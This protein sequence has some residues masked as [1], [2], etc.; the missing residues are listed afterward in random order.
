MLRLRRK[1]L[2]LHFL[3]SIILFINGCSTGLHQAAEK[4]NV[5]QLKK[6]IAQGVDINEINITGDTALHIAAKNGSLTSV[7]FLVKSGANIH[8]KNS[9]LETPLFAAAANGKTTIVQY[10]HQAGARLNVLN[11]HGNSP[12]F[13]AV[14]NGHIKTSTYLLLHGANP[15]LLNKYRETPVRTARQKGYQE[16]FKLLTEAK[17]KTKRTQPVLQVAPASTEDHIR[18]TISILHPLSRGINLVQT[19]SQI[20]IRGIVLDDHEVAQ[21]TINGTVV[22]FSAEGN[23][24]YSVALQNGQNQIYLLAIDRAGNQTSKVLTIQR[25]TKAV[26]HLANQ[27]HALIIGNN[28]YRYLNQLKTPVNDAAILADLLARNYGFKVSLIQNA[29]KE[30]ILRALNT[31]RRSLTEQDNLLIYY[32]GHGIYDKTVNKAYWLPVDAEKNDDTRWIIADTITTSI[33]RI[34]A[35]HILLIADSC[36]S[37]TLTRSSDKL[38]K[39]SHTRYQLIKRLKQ[40]KSRTLLASGGNEPVWDGGGGKHSIFANALINGLKR[41]PENQFTA[42][43][44]YSHFIKEDVAGNS[45]QIPVYS[46]IRHSGHKGGDFIFH[47]SP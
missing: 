10:L 24:Q 7:K 20:A 30:Q 44:L 8:S 32:A 19:S 1:T 41:I 34:Q 26:E 12:L 21:L 36:Y 31:Y 5:N 4:D 23:F 9:F 45:E 38:L 11:H 6:E 43:E 33:N 40:R 39:T 14:E 46:I 47:K 16:L 17:Q 42:E 22:A 29:N 13:A 25:R 35:H 27:Y 2:K 3:F 18:P 28:K 15:Y 37:G